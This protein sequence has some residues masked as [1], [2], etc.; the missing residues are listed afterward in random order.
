MKKPRKQ[1]LFAF[2]FLLF[3][4]TPLRADLFQWT[5]ARG[6]IHFTDNLN[7]VPE[8]VRNSPHLVI[9]ENVDMGGKTL[10]SEE[11][12]RR[13]PFLKPEAPMVVRTPEPVEGS[14]IIIQP[15]QNITHIVVVNQIVRRSKKKRCLTPKSCGR[16]FRANFNDRRYIHP[17]VFNGGSRQYIR[18]K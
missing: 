16:K 6:T 5:D 10:D 1:I 7:S 13:K 3:F 4:S 17:S 14:P 18:P 15:S 11:D 12:M 9:R 2:F 8:P